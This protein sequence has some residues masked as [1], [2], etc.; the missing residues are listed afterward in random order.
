MN[1]QEWRQLLHKINT[2]K[3]FFKKSDQASGQTL[4][5][6]RDGAPASRED[7]DGGSLELDERSSPEDKTTWEVNWRKDSDQYGLSLKTHFKT[8][9][10]KKKTSCILMELKTMK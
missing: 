6:M 4:Q 8:P 9:E 5:E 2:T 1:E 7:R 10:K 3:L